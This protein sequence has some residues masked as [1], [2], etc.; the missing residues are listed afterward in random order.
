[1][2]VDTSAQL[3]A[4]GPSSPAPAGSVGE[5]IDAAL[6]YVSTLPSLPARI[7]D[8]NRRRAAVSH[9]REIET[10]AR[11]IATIDRLPTS[12]SASCDSVGRG[13]SS[14]ALPWAKCAVGG[15]D[16]SSIGDAT[17]STPL[18]QSL[19]DYPLFAHT[20][21]LHLRRSGEIVYRTLLKRVR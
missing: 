5:G 6:R 8:E 2:E 4:T 19:S 12:L 18:Y 1:M 21:T 16:A 13:P 17:D 9:S 14:S 20:V 3:N 15:G 7:L 10:R 11:L